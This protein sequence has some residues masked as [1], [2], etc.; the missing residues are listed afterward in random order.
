M[1][2]NHLALKSSCIMEQIWQQAI[3][4]NHVPDLDTGRE[5]SSSHVP[6]N[7]YRLVCTGMR[8]KKKSDGRR[9]VKENYEVGV[10]WSAHNATRCAH[11]RERKY[12]TGLS[13]DRES[14]FHFSACGLVW[15]CR[16]MSTLAPFDEVYSVFDE[17]GR[18]QWTMS[19]RTFSYAMRT[20]IYLFTESI[21]AYKWDHGAK[22]E[23]LNYAKSTHSLITSWTIDAFG[24][25]NL[26]MEDL[27]EL[28]RRHSNKVGS[29]ACFTDVC[30][31]DIS[32]NTIELQRHITCGA[33]PVLAWTSR[34]RPLIHA[35]HLRDSKARIIIESQE[36]RSNTSLSCAVSVY[37]ILVKITNWLVA[38]SIHV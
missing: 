18:S 15:C 32:I 2:S 35:N 9:E 3:I 5:I 16:I 7:W 6:L 17:G 19:V 8:R 29:G 10:G 25:W 14:S 30:L 33:V 34:Y 22:H 37:H 36:D 24:T 31:K 4:T 26:T 1:L 28:G 21:S 13:W 27:G 20:A 12:S 38:W 23:L 11:Q